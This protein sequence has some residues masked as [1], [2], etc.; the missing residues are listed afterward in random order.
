MSRALPIAVTLLALFGSEA[1][2]CDPA[3]RLRLTDEIKSLTTKNAWPGVERKYNELEKARCVDLEVGTYIAAAQAA[4]ELGKTFEMYERLTAAQGKEQNEDVQANIQGILNNYGRV[5]IVG[6][7]RR[8]AALVREAMPFPPDQVKSIKYAQEVMQG[9]G[10]FKGMLPVGDYKVADIEFTVEAGQEFQ[11]ILI[12]KVKPPKDSGER[13][14]PVGIT[15][16][17]LVNWSGPVFAVGGGLFGS[18]EPD[19]YYKEDNTSYDQSPAI[20]FNGNNACGELGLLDDSS[21]YRDPDG[22]PSTPDDYCLWTS[23]QPGTIPLSTPTIDI[24]AGYEIGLTFSQPEMGV[25][26]LVNYRRTPT[27]KF[28]QITVQAAGVVRPGIFRITAGPTY[29]LVFGSSKSFASWT[30][31]GQKALLCDSTS[32]TED[33]PCLARKDYTV[34]GI[35]GGGGLAGSFGAALLDLGPFEGL[36][37]ADAHWMHDGRR[38]YSGIGL[39][40][41]VVPKLERFED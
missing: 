22:D 35:A 23:R 31:E 5:D 3:E 9:R 1:L 21:R 7:A 24:T 34:S 6:S 16:R 4:Q 17:G 25:L 19:Q 2:A 20:D 11:Q 33:P 14:E 41:G 38:A 26:A 37:E 8:V 12:G 18:R 29:G 27:R 10:S 15:N 40:L 30:D 39:R 28:N 13:P 32:Q 36:I